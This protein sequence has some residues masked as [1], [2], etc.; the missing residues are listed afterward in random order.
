MHARACVLV[1]CTIRGPIRLNRVTSR[2]KVS[3][4]LEPSEF[5]I[6]LQPTITGFGVKGE[7]AIV[8]A[9]M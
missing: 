8:V 2:G 3:T 7:D 4:L 1:Q 9:F 5:L 6:S